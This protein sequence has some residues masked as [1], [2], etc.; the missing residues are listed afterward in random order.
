MVTRFRGF[1]ADFPPDDAHAG[2]L[3][4]GHKDSSYPRLRS[5][6]DVIDQAHQVALKRLAPDA[7]CFVSVPR[8]FLTRRVI[9]SSGRFLSSGAGLFGYCL[10]SGRDSG[11]GAACGGGFDGRAA[12]SFLCGSLGGFDSGRLPG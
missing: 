3:V 11:G 9:G 5:F 4:A 1:E 10:C 12:G 6:I 2:V 7:S 8:F